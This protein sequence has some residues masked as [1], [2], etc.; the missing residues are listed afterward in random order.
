M[1]SLLCGLLSILLVFNSALPSLAQVPQAE[2]AL[3]RSARPRPTLL[4]KIHPNVSGI[5]K[6]PTVVSNVNRYLVQSAHALPVGKI[7]QEGL[8]IQQ[9]ITRQLQRQLPQTA[10]YHQW[11]QK[12]QITSF[13]QNMRAS[14]IAQL[15]EQAP[16]FRNEGVLAILTERVS[17]EQATVLKQFYQADIKRNLMAFSAFSKT[18]F[19]TILTDKT[20]APILRA[21]QN[22]LSSASALA[23]VGGPE[24][25]SLLLS[26]Y[27]A[28]QGTPFEQVA[29]RLTGRGL[30]KMRAYEAFNAWADPLAQEGEFWLGLTAYARRNQLPV[31]THASAGSKISAEAEGMVKWLEEGNLANGLNAEDSLLATESWMGLGERIEPELPVA[32]Q[33]V[34]PAQTVS[35]PQDPIRFSPLPET[36]SLAPAPVLTGQMAPI[37]LQSPSE[38]PIQPVATAPAQ[39]AVASISSSGSESG[40]LYSGLPIFSLLK[41]S[42]KA[43][44][45]VRSLW[46][47]E[48]N[49]TT[50]A[51][52]EE[53]GLHENTVRPI[54]EQTGPSSALDMEDAI[55]YANYPADIE[56]AESGFKLTLEDVSSVE[57][58][59]HNVNLTIDTEFKTAGYNRVVLRQDKV[60][61][62][63]NLT[64][65]AGEM[66]RFF[67]EL[68]NANA[69]LYKI[70]TFVTA[71]PSHRPMRIK[72]EQKPNQRYTPLFMTV[73]D[74]ETG[75][76]FNIQ[77]SVDANLLLKKISGGRSLSARFGAIPDELKGGKLLL[78]RDGKIYFQSA[79]GRKILLEDY[80]VRLPKEESNMW[81]AAMKA[82]PETNFNLKIYP[83]RNKTSFMTYVVSPL[84][85]GTGKAFGPIMS[86]L[87]L[88]PLFATGI[89]LFINNGVTI[90][91]GPLMPFLRRIGEANMCRLGIG[92]YALASTGALA[93]GLNGFMGLENA[94]AVQ[95]GGLIGVL[96]AMGVGG[97]L[98]N[99]TQ[100]NLVSA[101]AGVIKAARKAGKFKPGST[102]ST[103]PTLSYLGNRM[104]QLFKKGNVEMRDSVRYQWLSAFK[105]VGTFGFLSLPFFF[106]LASSAVGSSVRADFSLSFWA[107]AGMSSYALWKV[108]RM[109]MKDS[110]PRNAAVLQKVVVETEHNLLPLIEAELA[111][112]AEARNFLSLA[113]R[114]NEVLTPY[115]RAVSYRMPKGQRISAVDLEAKSLGRLGEELLK[116][117]LPAEQVETA[118]SE[119]QA[120]LN[121]LSRRNVNLRGVIKMK[122]VLPALTAMTFLT[123]HELGTASEFAYQVKKVAEQHFG[124]VG[125]EGAATGMFLTA[126][127]LY[128]TAFFSR[129]G[130][131]WIALRLSEGSM[132]AFSSALSV[133]GTSMLIVANGSIP[134]LF[135]GATMAT[136]G[137]GNFFSQIFEYTMKQAPKFRPELAVLIGYTMPVAAALTAGIHS[138]AE[139][140]TTHGIQELG[141]MTALGALV[142]SFAACP[143]MF[144]DSSII[145]SVQYYSKKAWTSLKKMFRRNGNPPAGNSA[146]GANEG[147]KEGLTEA[148]AH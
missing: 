111:K 59:L 42:K 14:S 106:N 74:L 12:S 137:M 108:L 41:V 81:T 67:F 105:N 113:K 25:A 103:D 107:L 51:V 15:T 69:E 109:P 53:P 65:P 43:W 84:R 144:A 75:A 129:V 36:I 134:L 7:S 60:F 62:L 82:M 46:R 80:H 3:V 133:L 4:Q 34:L 145:R 8:H 93:L 31:R 78:A 23:L 6:N 63:R 87:G 57:Q 100:N 117:G 104:K 97:A 38:N 124:G 13:T 70:V 102:G 112:P 30:L 52:A 127:F 54:Y 49:G 135:T 122:G 47:R 5:S 98:I 68:S 115:A 2:R 79:A 11:A 148:T 123:V 76:P 33:E 35:L 128:G 143:K 64:Q 99:V 44:N 146:S 48:Q 126:F 83:T 18:D 19:S 27:K 119:L 125:D 92:L 50:H 61:E 86:S 9:N 120:A 96:T 130:G 29:T 88:T 118:T 121:T 77:A 95:V 116:R 132:Y 140:G 26:L 24:E 20:S 147:S 139:W 39:K 32:Q 73:E 91:L 90:L 71:N 45:K 55:A 10:Q 142:A 40:I 114:L 56:V 94:T 138:L 141:L 85:I 136:F 16:L 101:N 110:V 89:P 72:L 58:I 22:A 21:C 66:S 1:R 17:A 28:A 37:R 131:N